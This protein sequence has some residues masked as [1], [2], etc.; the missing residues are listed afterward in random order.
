MKKMIAMLAA[1]CA[2]TLGGTSVYAADL[3]SLKKA[4]EQVLG[5]VDLSAFTNLVGDVNLESLHLENFSAE[6]V[7]IDGLVQGVKNSDFLKNL[8]TSNLNLD[9]LLGLLDDSELLSSV[10]IDSIDKDALMDSLE[11]E[12]V[13]STIDDL[14]ASAGKGESIADRVKA[15]AQ[16]ESV[17]QMFSAVTG[18]KDLSTVLK[19]LNTL[20]VTSIL[21]KGA[22]A[23]S[24]EKTGDNSDMAGALEKL[25]QLGSSA[26]K[27][28]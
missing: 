10:G 28:E 7:D 22:A 13:S 17:K 9:A 3:S 8:D 16:N 4:A 26:L 21:N 24:S 19:S 14:M 15:L 5:D 6:N 11:D 23:L 18:G 27:G 2:L 20:N 1:A 25:I 12:R